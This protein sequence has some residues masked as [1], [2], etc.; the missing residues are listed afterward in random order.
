MLAASGVMPRRAVERETMRCTLHR[1]DARVAVGGYMGWDF[2][3]VAMTA[4]NL[5]E[6]KIAIE[7]LFVKSPKNV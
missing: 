6:P 7:A 1:G 3:M 4:A 2:L 5:G